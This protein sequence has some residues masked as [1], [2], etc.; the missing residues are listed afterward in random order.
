MFNPAP[1]H[2]G[3]LSAGIAVYILIVGVWVSGQ[4][5]APAVVPPGKS[6]DSHYVWD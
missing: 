1:S 5:R 3:Y 6:P 2:D 4:I